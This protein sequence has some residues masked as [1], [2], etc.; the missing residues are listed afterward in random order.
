[1]LSE[2]DKIYEE[3][4]EDVCRNNVVIS[5]VTMNQKFTFNIEINLL[6]W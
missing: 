3:Y 4:M 2:N 5:G 6:S 1:M